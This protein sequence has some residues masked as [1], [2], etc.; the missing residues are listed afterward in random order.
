MS[1]TTIVRYLAPWK[2]KREQ[3]LARRLAALR[4]RDGDCCRRCRRPL[5]FD[6]PEGHDLGPKIESIAAVAEGEPPALDNLCLTHRRCHA[7]SIDHTS[8]VKERIRRKAEAELLSR[9][10]R[11]KSKAA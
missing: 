9:S 5:R 7:E 10:R 2:Y 3:E 6:L 4:Q 8:E 11:R 1:S